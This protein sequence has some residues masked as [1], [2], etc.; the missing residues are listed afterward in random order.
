MWVE[1]LVEVELEVAMA[2]PRPCLA[3][4]PTA[5]AETVPLTGG[6]KYETTLHTPKLGV[7][8]VVAVLA[9][10]VALV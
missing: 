3:I 10:V 2:T 8:G 5:T 6:G 4:Y 9:V 7:R 1:A